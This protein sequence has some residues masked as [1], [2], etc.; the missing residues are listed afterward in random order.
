M[1]ITYVIETLVTTGGT[2]RMVSEKANYLAEHLGYDV[3]IIACTQ[4]SEQ[5]NA[6]HLSN[7]I[8]QI[9][10]GIPYYKQYRYRYPKRLWIKH[11]INKEFRKLLTEEIQR[12]NPDILIGMGHFKANT[13]CNIDCEA[14]IIIESHEARYFTQSG[15]GQHQN[16][17]SMLFLNLYR[18]KYFRTIEKKADAVVTL[19]QGDKILWSNAKRV[20][21]IPNFSIMSIN[22]ISYNEEKR[23][24][25][26]GRLAWEKGYDRLIE[27]WRMVAPQHPD[28]HLDI[29]GEGEL[30]L[31]L[32]EKIVKNNIKN[33]FIHD[34]TDRI[35]NEYTKS[36]ICVMTSY[37]EG[38]ALVL[39][40][41]LRH[42]VPCIAFDCPFGPSS[43]IEDNQCG[44]LIDNGNIYQFVEKLSI[45]IENEKLRKDFSKAAIVR[46]EAFS[47]DRIMG[48]W[49][50]LFE[51]LK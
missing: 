12:Q 1:K 17:I 36:S 29:F 30:G 27:I 35:S 3:S 43:I 19:T 16:L 40:E 15:M 2:E 22:H 28:W 11:T 32:K 41:A 21:V 7:R 51:S 23:I 14:K 45:L 31:E 18:K 42:G 5:P 4:H 39:L 49:K 34:Y 26:V 20:E 8:N 33:I 50:T 13:V 44:F 9:F 6:F 46:S 37:Y 25:A 24:I 47:I 10:L 38:F 48:Q